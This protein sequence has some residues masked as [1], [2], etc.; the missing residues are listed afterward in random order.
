MKN[1]KITGYIIEHTAI[2][3]SRGKAIDSSCRMNN[4]T[5][6]YFTTEIECLDEEDLTAQYQLRRISV[7]EHDTNMLIYLSPWVSE[8]VYQDYLSPAWKLLDDRCSIKY[9]SIRFDA[10]MYEEPKFPKEITFQI[11]DQGRIFTRI[12]TQPN[13]YGQST[14][15]KIFFPL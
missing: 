13:I 11:D 5:V 14:P 4:D 12:Q 15:G 10:T 3:L 9:E 2:F 7:V 6:D 1:K 8:G